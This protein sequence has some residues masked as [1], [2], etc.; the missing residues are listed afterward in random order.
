MEDAEKLR[1]MADEEEFP[2]SR[3]IFNNPLYR[4]FSRAPEE[5]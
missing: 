5:D 1:K 2:H 3:L 4:H